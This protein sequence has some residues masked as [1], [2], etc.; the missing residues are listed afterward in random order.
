[1]FTLFSK[2][3]DLL[4]DPFLKPPTQEKS[5]SDI[6]NP[7]DAPFLTRSQNRAQTVEG[8]VTHVFHGHGLVDNEIYFSLSDVNGNHSLQVII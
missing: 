1:M 6:N 3:V 4:L 8:E 7:E 2:V 5:Y